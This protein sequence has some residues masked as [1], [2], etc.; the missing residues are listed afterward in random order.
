[1]DEISPRQRSITA[2]YNRVPDQVPCVPLI[3]NSY[4]APVLGVPV[5]QCFIDPVTHAQSLS[6]C[7]ERHPNIDGLSINLCLSKEI[8]L[9]Q[10]RTPDGFRI[11]TV[12]AMTWN[13]PYNDIG[14]V[15]EREIVSFDDPRLETDDPLKSGILET[16]SAMPAD[17]RQHYLINVGVTGPF[18]QVVFLM[19]LDRVMFAT[20]D[21]PA[22]LQRAIEKRL[23]LA[24]QWIEEM[25]ALQ[26]G[27][28]WIGEGVASSSLIGPKAYRQFVL[29]YEKIL[30]EKIRQA[31][32]PGILHICGKIDPIL[33]I[34]PESGIDCLEVDWLMDMG[35]AKGRVGKKISLK[36]N[37]NTTTLVQAGPEEIYKLSQDII[38]AAAAGGGLV[39]SS[40]CA[41]GRDTPPGNV[42]AMAQ[43]AIDFGRYSQ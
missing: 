20:V 10:Q 13:I 14:T 24:M 11:H 40:G 39:L 31:G 19:G 25:A 28:I 27:C 29:P 3:D 37:L 5:S 23:P 34:I 41:L 1:M 15:Q 17:I 38:Q 33:D 43:A 42:D 6:A 8:I 9:D 12:G 21:D 7:F 32:V 18:S 22:G 16:L 30:A 4:S 35:Q 2:L 26:P 36:G